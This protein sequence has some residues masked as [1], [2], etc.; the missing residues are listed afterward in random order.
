MEPV[1]VYRFDEIHPEISGNKWFKL[2]PYLLEAQAR[3]AAGLVTYGGVWSNHLLATARAAHLLDM[4]LTLMVKGYEAV[5]LTDTLEAC[6]KLNAELIFLDKK[7]FA[8]QQFSGGMDDSGRFHIP[9]GGCGTEGIRG[10]GDMSRYLFP[11]PGHLFLS[12]G[13]G[14]MAAGLAL[15][16]PET[17]IHAIE[18]AGDD[19]TLQRLKKL[20]RQPLTNLDL[21]TS[22]RYG[23]YARPDDSVLRLMKQLKQ[24]KDLPLDFVYTAK[25]FAAMMDIIK[26]SRDTDFT[27]TGFI[28]SGGLQGNTSLKD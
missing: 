3:N 9:A 24:E 26:N 12:A 27:N 10:A 4:P 25:A 18:A 19:H 16:L 7:P 17:K 1:K 6:K 14:T 20:T 5:P 13:F 15:A 2:R 8:A 21:Y 23:G 22:Y 11:A 28:H